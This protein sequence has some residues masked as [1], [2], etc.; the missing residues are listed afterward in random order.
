MRYELDK[1]GLTV[2]DPNIR[3]F[4]FCAAFDVE[5]VTSLRRTRLIRDYEDFL[6]E[7]IGV[8]SVDFGAARL[9][10]AFAMEMRDPNTLRPDFL[11]GTKLSLMSFNMMPPSFVPSGTRNL[12]TEMTLG[13]Q[14]AKLKRSPIN[15]TI[16]APRVWAME[17]FNG[18]QFQDWLDRQ[19]LLNQLVGDKMSSSRYHTAESIFPHLRPVWSLVADKVPEEAKRVLLAE[20]D[21]S[22]RRISLL[23]VEVDASMV[24]LAGPLLSFWLFLYLLSYVRH[25]QR[26]CQT[27]ANSLCTF[28]WLPLFP[29]LIAKMVS[30]VSILLLPFVVFI[31]LLI[32]FKEISTITLCVAILFTALSLLTAYFTWCRILALRNTFEEGKATGGSH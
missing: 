5:R 21:K 11:P 17:I 26:I 4:G 14:F 28:L 18:T 1:I 29:D 19:Q 7:N 10:E 9:A 13:V 24:V 15:I 25:L 22:R 20:V 30:F 32:R 16:T 27:D 8:H 3:I 2:T 12:T 6:I 31:W 23:G